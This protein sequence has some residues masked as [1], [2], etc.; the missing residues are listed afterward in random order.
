MLAAIILCGVLVLSMAALRDYMRGRLLNYAN[1]EE[2]SI[3][4][5]LPAELLVLRHEYVVS[6]SA[7]GPFMPQVEEGAR[8]KEGS[9]IGYCGSEPVYAQKGGAVSYLIDGWEGRLQISSLHELDWQQVFSQLEEE[10][11]REQEQD[12]TEDEKTRLEQSPVARVVDNLLDYTVLLKLQDPREL[13]AE[14]SRI[15]FRLQEGHTISAAYQEIWQTPQGDVYY[16]FNK[17]SSKE[18]ILF[19][20]RYSEAEVIAREVEGLIVPSSAITLDDEGRV[21][22]FIRK[23]R[24]LVFTEIEELASKDDFSVVSGLDKTAVVVTN[25]SRARDG[26]RI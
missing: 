10:Q 19:S 13:L 17:I 6:A 20:L 26:Q 5:T 2:G 3:I 15:T 21:G 22:V 4:L 9:L 7:A 23:K 1:V 11:G 18:D 8:V 12:T 25:P 24:K 14:V 16:I